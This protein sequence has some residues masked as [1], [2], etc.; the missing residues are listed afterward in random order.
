[1]TKSKYLEEIFWKDEKWVNKENLVVNPESIDAPKEICYLHGHSFKVQL[2]SI[3]K[4]MEN[5][6]NAF[7]KGIQK[8]RLDKN[9]VTLYYTPVQFYKI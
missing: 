1:M 3:E 9:E 4:E 2:I 7:A 6:P 5:E 8:Q